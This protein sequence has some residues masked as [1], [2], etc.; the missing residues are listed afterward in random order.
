[1]KK[2]QT[3]PYI[4]LYV[5]CAGKILSKS[6]HDRI[7]SVNHRCFR[8]L[9]DFELTLLC[10]AGETARKFES[11]YTGGTM[12]TVGGGEISQYW[13][14]CGA[15]DAFDPGCEAAPHMTYDD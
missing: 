10:V 14:C 11:V 7:K 3:R 4:I 5:P 13:H 2:P 12:E 8:V 1:M 15:P 6:A 9:Y